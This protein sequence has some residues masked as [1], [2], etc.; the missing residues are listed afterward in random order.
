MRRMEQHRHQAALQ[1]PHGRKSNGV[2]V[3]VGHSCPFFGPT[4]GIRGIIPSPWF[5]KGG[6]QA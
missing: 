3:D 5:P 2:S 4:W 6:A 1:V